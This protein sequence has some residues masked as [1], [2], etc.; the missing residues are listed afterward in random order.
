MMLDWLGRRRDDGAALRASQWIEE[1]VEAALRD[2]S[3]LTRDLG[4]SA[5]TVEAGDAVLRALDAVVAAA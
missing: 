5:G 2:G 4:G 1:A 3:G